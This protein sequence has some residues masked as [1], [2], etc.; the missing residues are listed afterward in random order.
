MNLERLSGRKIAV[1]MGGSSPE[2]EI[3]LMS[4]TTVLAALE[5]LGVVT[6]RVDTADSL[7]WQQLKGCELAFNCLH[8][9]G[10]EDGVV[11]GALE[12]L[13]VPYTGSGVLGSALA[14]DKL[15]SKRLWQG[16]GIATADFAELTADSDWQAII[17]RLGSTFV[18][19][20]NGG[21]SIGMARAADAEALSAAWQE[22]A[23]Y[24]D[25]VIAERFIEGEEFTVAILDQ[26]AL[27][28]IK[29]ETD[30]EFYDYQAKYF[31]DATR[32]L[33]PCGLSAKEE[34]EMSALAL[35]AFTSLGCKG[36]G[37]VDF[38][39]DVEGE[40][41]V[42]EVNTVPGMT[43]HSLVPMAAQA[44]DINLEELVGRIALLG[45]GGG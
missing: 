45:M 10:G 20:A 7:W 13:G 37:R 39:R 17:D 28:A 15:M 16:L 34:A 23:Q 5:A 36:W 41:W 3:S 21:S 2:R 19:P 9:A 40:L 24:G 35:E 6:L 26:R 11:Q 4:G 22:A 32:Y 38:M 25:A 8:G 1:L 12:T 18:K 33:C 29:L 44:L 27:P 14:M 43:S 42:L 30:N 31:S